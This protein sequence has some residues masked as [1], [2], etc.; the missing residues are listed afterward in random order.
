MFEHAGAW[1]WTHVVAALLIIWGDAN[2]TLEPALNKFEASIGLYTPPDTSDME[3]APFY[4]PP[5]EEEVD[6]T[7]ILPDRL[8]RENNESNIK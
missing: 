3:E 2:G 7:F 8:K 5:I 6:S 1:F 4:M